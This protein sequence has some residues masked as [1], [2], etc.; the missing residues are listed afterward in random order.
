MRNLKFLSTI[1]FTLP[2]LAACGSSTETIGKVNG[3]DISSRQFD[4]YLEL[5]RIPKDDDKKHSRA[6]EEYLQ[7]EAMTAAIGKTDKLK[8]ATLNAEVNEFKKQITI[9][10]YFEQYLK[11]A[12]NNE[13]VRNYYANNTEKYQSTKVHAA[14]I[15]LR[16]NSKMSETERQAL[17]TSAHE[18]HSKLQTGEDFSI[19]AK[20]NSQDKV[21]AEKG[22]DLGWLTDGAV[23][24]E[25]S[26]RLYALKPNEYTKPFLTSFG[27][28]IVKML[29]GPQVIK[30]PLEAVKGDI[31]Y[32]LRNEAKNAEVSRLLS[33]VKVSK[34]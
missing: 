3:N 19:L 4:A 12:V 18:I 16:V 10:R 1:I 21:S 28:H 25:F 11:N 33:T 6:L 23:S 24:P 7:R 17:L 8:K 2:L 5:K 29:E 15:L 20:A 13:S 32:Q 26:K 9:S 30:K 22:G 27:F 31:R 14:H 34:E